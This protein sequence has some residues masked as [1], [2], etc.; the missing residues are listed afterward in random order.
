MYFTPTPTATP[1]WVTFQYAVY[2]TYYTGA[3]YRAV[4]YVQ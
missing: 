1:Q 3:C 4:I 2:D